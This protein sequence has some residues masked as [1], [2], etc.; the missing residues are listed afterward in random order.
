[1]LIITLPFT[2]ARVGATPRPAR[3]ARPRPRPRPRPPAPAQPASQPATSTTTSSRAT[4]NNFATSRTFKQPTAGGRFHQHQRP[5]ATPR[6]PAPPAPSGATHDPAQPRI[7]TATATSATPPRHAVI[8]LKNP[9]SVHRRNR[10]CTQT[11]FLSVHRRCIEEPF[12]LQY[13]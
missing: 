5:G 10:E 3:P 6:P 1:M 13:A 7:Q 12:T 4:I 2:R 8:C 11:I 9:Q